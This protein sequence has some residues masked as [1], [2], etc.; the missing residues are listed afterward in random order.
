MPVKMF[1]PTTTIDKGTSTTLRHQDV[2][3]DLYCANIRLY[4]VVYQVQYMFI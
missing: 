2:R 3:I 1:P 4:I